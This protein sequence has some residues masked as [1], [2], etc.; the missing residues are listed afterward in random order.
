MPPY[1][2]GG[3]LIARV[4]ITTFLPDY[5]LSLWKDESLADANRQWGLHTHIIS[6]ILHSRTIKNRQ[7]MRAI[8]LIYR[9]SK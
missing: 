1:T 6:A 3:I 2:M 4:K 5:L 8:C 9:K 7:G